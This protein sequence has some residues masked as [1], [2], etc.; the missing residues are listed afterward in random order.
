MSTQ[1]FK[2]FIAGDEADAC[3]IIGFLLDK[4]FPKITVTMTAGSLSEANHYITAHNPDVFFLDIEFPKDSGFDLLNCFSAIQAAVVFVTAYE[5]YA[6]QNNNAAICDYI[7]KPVSRG[8]FRKSVSKI[9]SRLERI[10]KEKKRDTSFD[11]KGEVKKVKIPSSDGYS[12]VDAKS[13]VRCEANGSCTSIY[14]TAAP[15]VYVSKILLHYEKELSRFGF[16]RIHHKHLVN[17]NFIKSYSK[18]R[19]GGHVILNNGIEL[20]VSA[21]KKAALLRVMSVGI[22]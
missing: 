13:I 12:F 9:L 16:F 4:M 17:L 1:N 18:G 6:V 7:L 19:G 3:K 11:R 21:R 22:F 2:N 20:E 5:N 8:E 15:K 14:F 10:S